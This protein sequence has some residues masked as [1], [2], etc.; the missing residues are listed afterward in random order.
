MNFRT[1]KAAANPPRTPTTRPRPSTP[2]E[3]LPW[4]IGPAPAK[5]RKGNAHTT[6]PALKAAKFRAPA[7][8]SAIRLGPVVPTVAGFCHAMRP[9]AP[10][11]RPAF[12]WT[13][14]DAKPSG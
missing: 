10:E 6:A 4:P 3:T 5:I 8:S 14:P 2:P 11:V 13:M 9:A 12:R 7:K 1:R